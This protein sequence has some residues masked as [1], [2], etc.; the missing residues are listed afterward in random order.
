MK[1]NCWLVLGAMLATSAI[2]QDNTNSLP[3]MPAPVASPAAEMAPAPATTATAAPA[4]APVTAPVKHKKR[5]VAHM[6]AAVLKEPTVALVAG[7]AEVTVSNLIVRGQA[8]LKGEVV[9]HLSMGDAV[10]VLSQINLDKHT[11]D[12]PAQWAKIACPTNTHVWVSAKFIDATNN[13]V[14][15]KKLNL[16]AG[17][18]ENYSVLGVIERGTPVSE[19][20]TKDGW[21]EIE[22][23]ASTYAFVAAMYLKQ[24]AA[25]VVETNTN[26]APTADTNAAPMEAAPAPTPTPVPEAQPIVTE[27]TNAPASTESNPPPAVI[28]PRP[29]RRLVDTNLPPPPPRIA[30]HEGVVR[31]VGSLITPTEY[32]LYDPATDVNVD[33]LY[34]TTTNLDLSRYVGM[35]IIVTGEEGLAERWPDVPVLTIQRILVIDTNAVPQLIYRSPKAA[36]QRH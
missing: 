27:E 31:H 10:T 33:F 35:R 36:G 17:P 18:G 20:I 11:A 4:A 29:N 22:T 12:E 34:T 6:K 30:T 25:A 8:G 14:L 13:V 28:P 5:A 16:R 1:T 23:P 7:P 32:E 26:V 9:S 21:M 19:I 24:E 15:P 2:A 3:A